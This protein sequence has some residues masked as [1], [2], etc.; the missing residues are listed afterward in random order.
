MTPTRVFPRLRKTPAMIKEYSYFVN[1]CQLPIELY[2]YRSMK[3][4]T[5]MRIESQ[6]SHCK[7]IWRYKSSKIRTHFLQISAFWEVLFWSGGASGSASSKKS[8]TRIL[9]KKFEIA[10][11]VVHT[12]TLYTTWCIQTILKEVIKSALT[13]QRIKNSSSSFHNSPIFSPL[14]TQSFNL[15]LISPT[16]PAH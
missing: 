6:M 3:W 15:N 16:R 10:M 11:F 2:I 14:Q 7:K 4:H 13:H 9:S 1:C 12:H 5:A 8:D